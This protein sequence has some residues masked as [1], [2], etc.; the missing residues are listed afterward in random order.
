MTIKLP[1]VTHDHLMRTCEYYNNRNGFAHDDCG[2]L[3]W[4]DIFGSGI[5]RPRLYVKGVTGRGLHVS[6]WQGATMR[7]TLNNIEGGCGAQC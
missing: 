1:R 2:Y 5:Y 6:Q 3:Q 7:E 4:A